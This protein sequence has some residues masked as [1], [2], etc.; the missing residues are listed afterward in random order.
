MIIVHFPCGPE[1]AGASELE[2]GLNDF[3]GAAGEVTGRGG[4]GAD[5]DIFLQLVA[6]ED[7]EGWVARLCEFLRAA[8]VPAGAR[9][10]VFPDRWWP[11][12]AWREVAVYGE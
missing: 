4:S 9:L 5:W 11:G 1:E 7:T 6:G 2:G 10:A 8:G 3:L 12:E